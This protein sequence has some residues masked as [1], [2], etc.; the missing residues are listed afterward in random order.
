MAVA[1]AQGTNFA[2]GKPQALFETTIVPFSYP[3][4]PGNSYAVSR[5]GQR[6][7]VNYAIRK[8]APESITIVLPPR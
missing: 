7:L 3:A 5:D 8:T 4:L 6:F 1:I 2:A